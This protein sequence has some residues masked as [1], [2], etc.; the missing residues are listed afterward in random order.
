VQRE[1]NLLEVDIKNRVCHPQREWSPRKLST[2][3]VNLALK[4]QRTAVPFLAFVRRP[5]IVVVLA[6]L[7]QRLFDF[8]NFHRCWQERNKIGIGGLIVEQI[9][10]AANQASRIPTG[11]PSEPGRAGVATGNTN[12]QVRETNLATTWKMHRPQ[13]NSWTKSSCALK[14]A[15]PFKSNPSRALVQFI[16]T[17]VIALARAKVERRPGLDPTLAPLALDP[18]GLCLGDA[19][20]GFHRVPPTAVQCRIETRQLVRHPHSLVSARGSLSFSHFPCLFSFSIESLLSST[21]NSRFF[22]AKVSLFLALKPAPSDARGS[23]AAPRPTAPRN[24]AA[25]YAIPCRRRVGLAFDCRQVKTH[26]SASQWN[27]GNS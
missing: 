19:C 9:A 27:R 11:M 16:C 23:P 25:A 22:R 5:R 21:S 4:C 24:P 1:K 7:A 12:F 6:Q 13:F 15:S 18:L 2:D 3:R 17:R 14:S 20:A 26:L 8:C 10:V